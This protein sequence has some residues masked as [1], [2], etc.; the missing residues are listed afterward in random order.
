MG[1]H[2]SHGAVTTDSHLEVPLDQRHYADLAAA[3]LIPFASLIQRGLSA[4]L[5][6]HV[7]Y[8]QE[9][10]S[11]GVFSVLAADRSARTPGFYRG[12][13]QRRSG[14]GRRGLGRRSLSAPAG[15]DCRLR[16]WCW[17]VM[18]GQQ[19]ALFWTVY[20]HRINPLACSAWNSCARGP[21]AASLSDLHQ[22]DTLAAGT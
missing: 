1:K 16:S 7:I 4:V 12:H 21:A 17:P 13:H 11:G 19:P 14:Y 6:A 18:T 20:L 3:D 2:F 8:I 10:Q 15:P 22:A 5:P 9:D